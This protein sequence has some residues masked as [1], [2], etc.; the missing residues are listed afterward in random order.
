MERPQ[1]AKVGD[2]VLEAATIAA[3][4]GM[5]VRASVSFLPLT[6]VSYVLMAACSKAP[7]PGGSSTSCLRLPF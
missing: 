5:M 4:Y 1:F 3:Q 2:D 6:L 7:S